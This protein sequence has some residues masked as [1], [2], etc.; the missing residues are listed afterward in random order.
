MSDVVASAWA[1]V[2]VLVAALVAVCLL[3]LIVVVITAVVSSLRG[4]PAP[5]QR[6]RR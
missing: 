1:L 6:G 5:W 3:A 2:G 4:R